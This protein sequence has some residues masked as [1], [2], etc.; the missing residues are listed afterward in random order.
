MPG[1]ARRDSQQRHE[2]LQLLDRGLRAAWRERLAAAGV[3]EQPLIYLLRKQA[4]DVPLLPHELGRVLYQLAQRRGF[5]SNRREQ[6][7]ADAA[8]ESKKKTDKAK[9]EASKV[10]KGIN[11]LKTEMEA[12]GS[13]TVGEYFARLSTAGRA[14]RGPDKWTDRKWFVAEF[15]AVWQAQAS[16]HGALTPELRQRVSQ[17]LFYQRPIAENGHLIG[18]CELEPTE[19]RAPM[20]HMLAQRFRYLQKLNDLAI[21]EAPNPRPLTSEQ[22]A[23]LLP[24]FENK[25]DLKFDDI[26]KLLGCDKS[27]RF[28]LERGGEKKLPG[29]RTNA[30]MI[31]AIPELWP[32]LPDA[33]KN[34]IVA[35]WIDANDD[36]DL[37]AR[38]TT[39][40]ALSLEDASAI[41]KVHPEDRYHNVSLLAMSQLM[42]LMEQGVAFKTAEAKVYGTN[43]SGGKPLDSLPP[44][45]VALPSIPNPAVMRALS[46]LRKV[47]NAIVRRHDKPTLVR[48]ELARDLK[49]NAKQ[50]ELDWRGN[51]DR[52][53]ARNAA[54]KRILDEAN[55]P[56]ATPR[57]VERV[58]LYEECDG[59]CV[60]CGEQ[61][62]FHRLFE[63]DIDVDHILPQ[64]RFP[65][66]SFANKCLA[67]RA[68]NQRK[69]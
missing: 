39:R 25:G 42:P 3:P 46:E 16:H 58:L 69:V 27:V 56:N 43:F 55:R 5:K 12:A 10:Y 64:S 18:K 44:A 62:N 63:G 29:N 17:L 34:A 54:A 1:T 53:S 15:E 13:R 49:R 11:D 68:C 60:Y 40:C 2:I 33:D 37:I 30:A 8:N 9:D 32:T 6:A 59:R 52:E 67:H 24:E 61:I 38:L 36:E 51:R 19:R 57:E 41:C 21:D 22:R 66:D 35:Q 26:R 50:R 48:I 31:R 4:L 7:A 14:V 23:I 47:V 45:K 28:N 65:D 20:A